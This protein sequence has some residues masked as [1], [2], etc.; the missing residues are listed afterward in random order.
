MLGGIGVCVGYGLWGWKVVKCLGGRLAY[1]TPSRAFSVQFCT[2]VTVLFAMLLR[3]PISTTHILIGAILGVSIV[4]N[5]KVMLIFYVQGIAVLANV[6]FCYFIF[7]S[8]QLF[9]PRKCNCCI[10]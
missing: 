6:L 4:D 5:I 3:L 2:L 10:F 1:L 9:I 7:I 8:R